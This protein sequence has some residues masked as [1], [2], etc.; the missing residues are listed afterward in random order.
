L[1]SPPAQRQTSE[2]Y[3][4]HAVDKERGVERGGAQRGGEGGKGGGGR[5]RRCSAVH[6]GSV[7]NAL[8]NP[9]K[10]GCAKPFKRL[11]MTHTNK[12]GGGRGGG[13]A[14]GGGYA[15]TL[16][17]SKSLWIRVSPN[18]SKSLIHSKF[19]GASSLLSPATPPCR[20]SSA[21]GLG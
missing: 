4:S 21:L 6:S 9:K 18:C 15:K 20:P 7:V 8:V 11:A 1:E 14:G 19:V 5:G 10:G 13:G 2:R 3:A 16:A 17:N 12:A